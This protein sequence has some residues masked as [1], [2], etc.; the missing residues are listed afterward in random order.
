MWNSAQSRNGAAPGG[1]EITANAPFSSSRFPL[2]QVIGAFLPLR[3][4]ESGVI[5]AFLPLRKAESGVMGA[6][7]PLRK[8]E[9]G[10]I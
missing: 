9:S 1:W 10:F 3:K 7:L 2:F 5:G 8:A 6:F 4:A